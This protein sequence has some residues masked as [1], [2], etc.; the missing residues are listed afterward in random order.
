MVQCSCCNLYKH[1]HEYYNSK[2][3]CKQCVQYAE[4]KRRANMSPIEME[5]YKKKKKERKLEQI[6]RLM[7]IKMEIGCIDC[8]NKNPLCL[9]FDHQHS[10]VKNLSD[11][12]GGKWEKI[13]YELSKCEVRCSNC[14][15]IKTAREFNTGPYIAYMEMLAYDESIGNNTIAEDFLDGVE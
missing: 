4:K 2:K 8:G 15:R 6:V 9:D 7:Q 14:H 10:K 12:C 5:E 11:M 1:E 13:E 3:Q